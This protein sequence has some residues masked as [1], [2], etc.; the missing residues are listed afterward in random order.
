[1]KLRFVWLLMLML[2]M[3]CGMA[4]EIERIVQ[5]FDD[6][7][8]AGGVECTNFT[9]IDHN[10]GF[11]DAGAGA[12][13]IGINTLTAKLI[14]ICVANSGSTGSD[15]GPTDDQG[16][17]YW[18]L[19]KKGDPAG[20]G[21]NQIWYATNLTENISTIVS[22]TRSNCVLM[23]SSWSCDGT[24]TLDA[25]AAGNATDGSTFVTSLN[26][27][28]ATPS[29]CG[30]LFIASLTATTNTST[31][32]ADSGFEMLDQ[33]VVSDYLYGADAWKQSVTPENPTFSWS[34][35]G[36][37]ATE[38]AVFKSGTAP[39][40]S[41]W[42]LI[43]HTSK[44]GNTTTVTTDPIDTSGATFLYAYGGF[45]NGTTNGF[46]DSKGNSWTPLEPGGAGTQLSQAYWCV[47]TSVGGSH[48]FQ[49]DAAFPGL[50]VLAYSGANATPF[51]VQTNGFDTGSTATTI[52]AFGPRTPS[53]NGCLIIS[54]VNCGLNDF[55]STVDSGFGVVEY[56]QNTSAGAGNHLNFAVGTNIQTTATSVNPTWTTSSGGVTAKSTL[57]SGWKPQ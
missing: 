56:V 25:Q 3:Q 2:S 40:P 14:V 13:T 46:T 36:L 6:P 19:N 57:L 42:T 24:P 55:T 10:V 8:A 35:G 31:V 17:T 7:P 22:C 1:M 26:T 49:F 41:G 45:Y 23:G 15:A 32:S 16:N 33:A 28:S 5:F 34:V 29:A 43:A 20:V 44:G 18:P 21:T 50:I 51:D 38:M 30:R 48:T 11:N 47:P 27:G 12:T 52:Q 37:A 54:A 39:P 9:L 4:V 53:V